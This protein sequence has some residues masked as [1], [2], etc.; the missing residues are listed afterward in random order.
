MAGTHC[1]DQTSPILTEYHITVPTLH[2]VHHERR[3]LDCLRATPSVEWLKNINLCSPLTN[4]RL[5][6]TSVRRYVHVEVH[7][8]RRINWSSVFTFCKNWLKHPL[9]IALLA[10]LLCVAAAGGMLILLLLGLLNRAFPSKPLRHHW[11]EIDNQIL[12]ALFTLMSIYQHPGLIHHLVLLC[13]WRAEDAAELRKVYCKNGDRRPGERA[14]MS[15]VVA[16]LH[17][18]CISQ[19][20]VCN[21]YWAYRRRSRSEFADNFFFVL[22]VVA[23]VIAGAYTVYS[24]LGRDGD[25]ASGE[26]TKQ[27]HT[28]EAELPE[29]RTLIGDPVWAGGLLDCGEDPAA[30]CLSSLC[31]F[32]VFG[33]NMERLGF[34]N[35]YVHTAMFLLLCVAPFWVFNITALNIHDYVLGDAVGAA[36]IA[37]CFLGLLYGGFWRVQMRKRF[38]L[39]GSRWCCGSASLRD[40]AQWLFCWPCALAQEV[41]T[42][43]LYDVEDGGFYE[44]AVD[45][46]DADDGAASTSAVELPVSVGVAAGDVKLGLDGEMIAPARPMMETGERQ[47]GAADVAANGCTELKS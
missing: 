40:Y 24:P 13:R 47:T 30:C 34:G 8:I 46:G 41:R 39:P 33:W 10:W 1:S 20:V 23:P 43:N 18:T 14:H 6:S 16:L 12:N 36:G 38:A 3:L 45:G 22:G 2:E 27:Q 37:L 7:F 32:C 9:N 44:K 11:I 4:F 21:L 28:S 15:V 25:A 19:Y 31:T 5:P 35:M 17:L 42:G 29:T 26:E